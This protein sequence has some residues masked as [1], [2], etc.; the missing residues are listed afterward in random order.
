MICRQVSAQLKSLAP[1]LIQYIFIEHLLWAVLFQVVGICYTEGPC[2]CS[3]DRE[4]IPDTNLHSNIMSDV[5]RAV[6]RKKLGPGVWGVQFEVGLVGNSF[7]RRLRVETRD[8][9]HVGS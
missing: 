3:D 5:L 6:E 2:L 7:S 4:Q 1:K 8:R 9:S